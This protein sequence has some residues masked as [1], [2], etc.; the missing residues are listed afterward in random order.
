MIFQAGVRRI[1]AVAATGQFQQH[2]MIVRA[3]Q[4]HSTL[5]Q[6]PSGQAPKRIRSAMA[7]LV[8]QL[9]NQILLSQQQQGNIALMRSFMTVTTSVRTRQHESDADDTSSTISSSTSTTSRSMISL[10]LE[11]GA[12]E[13]D[14]D[15]YVILLLSDAYLLASYFV[16]ISL[17]HLLVF[18]L[19]SR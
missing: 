1:A 18:F 10:N 9:T 2:R 19:Q 5:R 6:L 17:V 12:L 13:E 8:Q 11:C 3:I 14:D 15:G 4:N 16:L 7:P